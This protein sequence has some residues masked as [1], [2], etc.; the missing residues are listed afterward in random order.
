M[1]YQYTEAIAL[2]DADLEAKKDKI[3]QLEAALKKMQTLQVQVVS[4]STLSDQSDKSM[5]PSA[6]YLSSLKSTT[7]PITDKEID[8]RGSLSIE[9]KSP[10]SSASKRRQKEITEEATPVFNNTSRPILTRSGIDSLSPK[11]DMIL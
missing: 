11:G 10:H 3:S 5:D 4:D 8:K 9:F 1:A 6:D 7:D 2:K